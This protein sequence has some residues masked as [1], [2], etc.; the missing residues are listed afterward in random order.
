MEKPMVQIVIPVYRAEKTI[1]RCLDSVIGQTFRDWQAVLADDASDDGSLDILME[2]AANDRR[3]TVLR[4]TQNQGAA[5][6][7][8]TAMEHLFGEYTAFLDADDYWEPAMLETLVGAATDNDCDVVQCRYLYDLPG[9]KQIVPK[10]VFSRDMLLCG[11]EMKKVYIKMMTGINMNHVCMKLIRTSLIQNLRFDTAL[12][13]AEDLDFCVGLF[14]DVKR[15]YFINQPLYHYFR[16]GTSIT[17]S[18]LPF[19]ERLKANRKVSR[20]MLSALPAWKT[21]SLFY[22][23]M[24]LARPYIIML[25]KVWRML[26]EKLA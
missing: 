10:G 4:H 2:Y 1:R 16:S 15:Y 8:N 18:G 7:R 9:G 26:R 25:S 21:D 6:A 17:G 5:A 13:T 11:R 3:F 23:A 20:K 12:P 14:C 19:G 24:A 22:K